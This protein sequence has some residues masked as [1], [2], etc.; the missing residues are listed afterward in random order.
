MPKAVSFEQML[1]GGAPN[2]LEHTLEA[3]ATVV[4]APKRLRELID[5]L[6]S[7]DEVVRVRVS[8]TLNRLSQLDKEL[9]AT[10][11]DYYLDAIEG[12]DQPS[13][14]WTRAQI[15]LEMEAV[16]TVA[17]RKRLTEALKQQIIRSEDWVVIA[18]T[19]TTL[20]SWAVE[21]AELAQWLV[22]HATRHAQDPRKTVSSAARRALETLVL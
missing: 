10:H 17:Q 8:S 12:L 9:F 21:D 1:T 7:A 15:A 18:H 3:V 4:A 20:V 13:A 19:L 5:T 14:E 11:M 22:P 6:D 16:L 2:A